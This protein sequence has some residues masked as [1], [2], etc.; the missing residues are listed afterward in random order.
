[1]ASISLIE[2]VKLKR[3]HECRKMDVCVI[4]QSHTIKAYARKNMNEARVLIIIKKIIFGEKMDTKNN[5]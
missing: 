3:R 1:M 4:M 5:V 2:L